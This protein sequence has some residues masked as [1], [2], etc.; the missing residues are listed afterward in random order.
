MAKQH[1]FLKLNPPRTSYVIGMANDETLVMKHYGKYWKPSVDKVIVLV[2][3]SVS[4][5]REGAGVVIIGA[6][7]E[8]QLET[9][10]AN[11]PPNGLNKYELYP[12]RATS[13]FI[14][15]TD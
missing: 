8:M 3:G 2:P 13:R 9:R 6:E 5:L 4:C 10:K 12:I 7:D 11:D 15:S 14:V 1:F